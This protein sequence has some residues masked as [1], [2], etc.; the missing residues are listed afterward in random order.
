ML[1]RVSSTQGQDGCTL[2]TIRPS[3]LQAGSR[4]AI[5]IFRISQSVESWVATFAADS[6][7]VKV[8]SFWR[9]TIH[10]SSC[11]F[12]LTFHGTP[13]SWTLSRLVVTFT[14]RQRR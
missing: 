1:Y 2:R 9:Q 6:F 12:S 3:L 7:P 14:A 13:R 4:P 8:G 10:R 5:Q 11:A